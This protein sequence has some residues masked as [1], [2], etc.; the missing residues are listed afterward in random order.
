[1]NAVCFKCG[2]EK[3]KPMMMCGQC[4]TLPETRDE[5]IIS[6]GL[7]I[8]CI[9]AEKVVVAAKY[10]RKKGRPPKL[11]EQVRA[12]AKRLVRK[13]KFPDDVSK[14]IE[15]SASF[16]ELDDLIEDD[17]PVPVI[18]DVHSIGKPASGEFE[19]FSNAPT[20]REISWTVGVDI[21]ELDY[22]KYADEK[23]EI[24]GWFRWI[25]EAWQQ[26]FVAKAEFYQ[27]RELS[28]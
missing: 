22:Q 4:H 28:T 12:K 15:L 24:Y 17:S 11:H 21:T 10:I 3:N 8:Q 27:L 14:S 13:F 7:S 2:G 6:M 26:K 25:D 1:M 19:A 23:G 5:K 9:K 18:I 16:F 20:Y